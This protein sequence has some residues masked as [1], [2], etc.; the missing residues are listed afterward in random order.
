[1]SGIL[2]EVA[3]VVISSG[4]GGGGREGGKAVSESN[5]AT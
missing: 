2:R 5:K 4:G 3:P 1:M